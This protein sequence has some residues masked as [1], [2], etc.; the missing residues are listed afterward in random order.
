M[1]DRRK[2]TILIVNTVLSLIGTVVGYLVMVASVMG[3]A[4]AQGHETLGTIIVILGLGLPFAFPLSI[5]GS[6]AAMKWTRVS[7][8]FVALPWVYT[9]L[10]FATIGVL[11]A[12]M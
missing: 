7:M 1:S 6:W 10:L 11:F 9:L 8:A 4:N 3:G 2:L 5:L 12:Q